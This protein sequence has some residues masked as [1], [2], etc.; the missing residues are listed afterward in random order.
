MPGAALAR[1]QENILG[2]QF[3][4]GGPGLERINGA[5]FLGRRCRTSAQLDNLYRESGLA[6]RDPVSEEI[7]QIRSLQSSR[8]RHRYA[9]VFAS[10]YFEMIGLRGH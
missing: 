3:I 9:K 10:P 4:R 7:R 2:E 6:S 1:L 5:T 8:N